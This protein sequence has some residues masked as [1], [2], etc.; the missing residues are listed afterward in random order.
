MNKVPQDTVNSE[1]KMLVRRNFSVNS[2]LGLRDQVSDGQLFKHHTKIPRL[3]SQSRSN[4]GAGDS[5]K[6]YLFPIHKS[7]IEQI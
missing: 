2:Q 1:T 6:H 7:M 5:L 4:H 3:K